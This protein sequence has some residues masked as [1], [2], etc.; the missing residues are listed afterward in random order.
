MPPEKEVDDEDTC[1]RRL[2]SLSESCAHTADS[3]AIPAEWHGSRKQYGERSSDRA[4]QGP[5]LVLPLLLQTASIGP[6]RTSGRART[7]AEGRY[8]FMGVA[9]G[10]YQISPLNPL[11]VL[12]V[13]NAW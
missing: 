6:S 7:D 13:A 5:S 1:A 8:Q 4:G 11:Y 9:A 2:A 3:R 12:P 10:A